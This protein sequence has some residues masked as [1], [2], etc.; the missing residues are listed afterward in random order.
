M[1][2]LYVKNHLKCRDHLKRRKREIA[3]ARRK[4]KP[5]T[6]EKSEVIDE[7]KLECDTIRKCKH[8]HRNILGR[9]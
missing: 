1:I 5:K 8:K 4:I 2:E 6:P 3:A 7:F 9:L